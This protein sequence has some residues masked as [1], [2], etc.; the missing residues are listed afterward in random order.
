VLDPSLYGWPTLELAQYMLHTNELALSA[1]T[2][3]AR[4]LTIRCSSH[5]GA[6]LRR[7]ARPYPLAEQVVQAQLWG[8]PGSTR[9]PR[10]SPVGAPPPVARWSSTCF[11]NSLDKYNTQ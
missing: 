5:L 8:M 9:L 7:L 2:E 11:N 1:L 10:V 4:A 6:L 3:L